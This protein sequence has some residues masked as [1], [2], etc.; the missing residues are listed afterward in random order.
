[1]YNITVDFGEIGTETLDVFCMGNQKPHTKSNSMEIGIK[2]F[3]L[4]LLLLL[5]LLY[6][7]HVSLDL[8]RIYIDL[9]PYEVR[10]SPIKL[11]SMVL[12]ERKMLTIGSRAKSRS[13][14]E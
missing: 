9:G 4:L 10:I 7:E 11:S 14:S 5:V 1:M 3:V 8:T 6:F 12:H 13:L 2:L